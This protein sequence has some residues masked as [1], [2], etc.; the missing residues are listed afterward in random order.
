MGELGRDEDVV[1]V[2]ERGLAICRSLGIDRTHGVYLDA[3]GAEAQWRLGQWDEALARMLDANRRLPTGYWVYFNAAPLQVERGELEIAAATFGD[4]RLPEGTA[5][6]QNLLEF[7][8][9]QASLAIWQDR[10]ELVR[11]IVDRDPRTSAPANVRRRHRPA[12]V[13]GRMG[14]SRPRRAGPSAS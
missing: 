3:N 6:L 7:R 10:P 5:T 13:A 12:A 11:S 4:G 9:G 1:A 8:T 2:A 14:R